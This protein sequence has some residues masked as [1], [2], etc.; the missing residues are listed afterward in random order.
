[1]RKRIT[2]I[3]I[4]SVFLAAGAVTCALRWKAWF[5]N[6]PEPVWLGEEVDYH[7]HTFG[8][9]SVPNFV[10]VGTTW[11]S[12][13]DTDRLEILLFGDVH[14]HLSHERYQALGDLYPQLDAYAQLGDWL[15]RGYAYYAEQLKSDLKGTLFESLPVMNTPGNHEYKK[16][17]V[18]KL[19]NLWYSLFK[20][21]LNGPTNG[22]GS[23][24][25]VDFCNLRWIVIDT[26]APHL[27]HHFTR[28]NKWLKQTLRGAGDKF[29]VVIMHHPVYSHAK[30]RWNGRV[31]L[32][33]GR[34]L[35]EADLV[36]S[37]HNHIYVRQLPFVETGSVHRPHR[38]KKGIHAEKISQQPVYELLTVSADSLL[39]RTY[40]LDTDSLFDRVTLFPS[41]NR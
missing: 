39:M 19:P 20:H 28:L 41:S 35:R 26:S 34:S 8:Q 2:W 16:G 37:G 18:K 38:M 13:R 33:L 14:N 30:G 12:L 7:F 3:I 5:V 11:Y 40:D 4:I 15:D 36:F 25:Y 21:P 9:D 23:T 1:M 24:Y 6:P 27:L 29:T 31:F 17:L 10:N 32:Y 22:L